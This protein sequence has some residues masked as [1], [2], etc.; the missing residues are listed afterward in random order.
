MIAILRR[1]GCFGRLVFRKL[2][3]RLFSI[4]GSLREG[5][6]FFASFISRMPLLCSWTTNS[7]WKIAI[8]G[9]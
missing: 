8:V 5:S 6:V 3:C 7:L 4:G 1:N 2:R 9:M